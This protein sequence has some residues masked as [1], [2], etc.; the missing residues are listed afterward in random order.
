MVTRR[1]FLAAMIMGCASAACTA[2]SVTVTP[3]EEV[4]AAVKV[5]RGPLPAG[6]SHETSR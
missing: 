2:P 3:T 5:Y 4:A 1:K 6:G